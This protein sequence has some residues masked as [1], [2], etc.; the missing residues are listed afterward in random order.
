MIQ[1]FTIRSSVAAHFSA[2]ARVGRKYAPVL[3]NPN[4][5]SKML[6]TFRFMARTLP[7][8]IALLLGCL[9]IVGADISTNTVSKL[10]L[11]VLNLDTT[12]REEMVAEINK[13]RLE[14][15]QLRSENQQL[16]RLLVDREKAPVDAPATDAS[17]ARQDLEE[18]EPE[19][20]VLELWLT[21]T[22]GKRHN[23]RCRYYRTTAG[24]SCGPDEGTPCKICGG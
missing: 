20:I 12:S 13:L 21:G 7:A 14:N 9:L 23:N 16:R 24:R 17:T 5:D 2:R 4:R 11:E 1:K 8:L 15:R 19:E 6:I 18:L 3:K 10:T 22:S